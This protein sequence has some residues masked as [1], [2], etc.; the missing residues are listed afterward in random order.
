MKI[1]EIDEKNSSTFDDEILKGPVFVKFYMTGCIHCENIK[2]TWKLLENEMKN[3][4]RNLS[5]IN[6]NSNALNNIKWSK[7]SEVQGFPTIM[8]IY[9]KGNLFKMYEGDRTLEDMKKFINDFLNEGM[10]GGRG[11]HRSNI[12]KKNSKRTKRHFKVKSRKSRKS[13]S[14]QYKNKKNKRKTR[15]TKK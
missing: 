8:M 14:K 11:K 4:N 13:K 9:N 2:P 12:R 5:L 3:D 1:I 7:V 6:V 15:R 10:S